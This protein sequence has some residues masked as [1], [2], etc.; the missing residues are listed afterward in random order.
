MH[1]YPAHP[2]LTSSVI[3]VSGN[4]SF[5]AEQGFHCAEM[6]GNWRL[7]DHSAITQG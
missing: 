7:I 4:L 3:K 2:L 5:G 6:F 1:R